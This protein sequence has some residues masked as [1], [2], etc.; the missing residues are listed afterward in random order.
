MATSRIILAHLDRNPDPEL[1]AEVAARGATLEYDTL[2]RTKYH[3]D[4]VVLDLIESMVAAGHG[5]RIL[6][7][8]DLGRRDSFRSHGGGPGMRH[9]MATFVPRLRRRI[10]DQATDAILVAN[11]ARAFALAAVTP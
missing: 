4:S 6:L 7:G 9:L 1:H 11:P 3:P 5:A 10:G 8:C 2:G